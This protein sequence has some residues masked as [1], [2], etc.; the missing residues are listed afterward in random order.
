MPLMDS[1]PDTVIG[2]RWRM[3]VGFLICYGIRGVELNHLRW[4]P[5][6]NELWSDYIKVNK[7]GETKPRM[8]LPI[9]PEDMPGLSKKLILEWTTK[10][11]QMP[12]LGYDDSQAS[13]A[14]LNYLLRRPIFKQ[15]RVNTQKEG[16]RLSIY[17]FRHRY[18]KQLDSYNFQARASAVL[19]GHSRN[20]FERS[21]GDKELSPDE[22]KAQA[23]TLM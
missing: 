13:L 22:L 1:F 6:R 18:A 14:I 2:Q 10:L 8:L 19:M 15:L 5:E 4:D 11:T 7:A 12:A 17:S 20:T 21:Y 23:A 3:A 16:R 9:D